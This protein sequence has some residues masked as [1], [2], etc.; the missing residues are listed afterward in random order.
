MKNVGVFKN[1]KVY[2]T[3]ENTIFLVFM[4]FHDCFR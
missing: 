4:T 3:A 1:K 2:T